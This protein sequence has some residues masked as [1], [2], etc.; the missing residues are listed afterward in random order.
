RAV[1]R[2]AL[3]L[4]TVVASAFPFM[5]RSM[6]CKRRLIARNALEAKLCFHLCRYREGLSWRCLP[7]PRETLPVSWQRRANDDTNGCKHER[8]LEWPH[9][10]GGAL[11]RPNLEWPG[12][13]LPSLGWCDEALQT[14]FCRESNR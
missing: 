9:L 13:T 1:S 7:I 2:A 3:V 11:D 12:G 8:R 14:R 6:I 5:H 4:N 10:Q